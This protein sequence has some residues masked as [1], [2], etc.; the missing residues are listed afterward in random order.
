MTEKDLP[1]QVYEIHDHYLIECFPWCR[2][3]QELQVRPLLSDQWF[4]PGQT[5]PRRFVWCFYLQ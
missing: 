3:F 5:D 4:F 1:H 2:Y